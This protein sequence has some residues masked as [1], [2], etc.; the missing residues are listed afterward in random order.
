[1]FYIVFYKLIKKYC[2]KHYIQKKEHIK[3]KKAIKTFLENHKNIY[4]QKLKTIIYLAQMQN[5]IGN[6]K[7]IMSMKILLSP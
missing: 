4:R 2:T 3:F 1:M 5:N 7:K 6:N